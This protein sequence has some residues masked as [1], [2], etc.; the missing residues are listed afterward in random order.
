[1]KDTETLEKIKI[2]EDESDLTISKAEEAQ[3]EKIATAKKRAEDILEKAE[4]KA[5]LEYRNILLD[6]NKKINKQKDNME[7][8]HLEHISGIRKI[9]KKQAMKIFESSIKKVFGV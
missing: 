7:G 4:S 1:M 5:E 8:E 2:K 9:T 3:V 6:S